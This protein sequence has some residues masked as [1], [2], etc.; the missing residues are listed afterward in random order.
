MGIA[1][2]VIIVLN[3]ATLIAIILSNKNKP[4]RPPAVLLGNG[5]QI[6]VRNSN[7]VWEIGII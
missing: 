4:P 6:S 2:F 3:V 1:E 5:W 7:K